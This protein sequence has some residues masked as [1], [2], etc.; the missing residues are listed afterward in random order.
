MAIDGRDRF[1]TARILAA[2]AFRRKEASHHDWARLPI[3]EKLDTLV[4]L[5]ELTLALHPPAGPNDAR[6]VWRTSDS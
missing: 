6:R 4:R 1:E 3:E 5:Q 2:E